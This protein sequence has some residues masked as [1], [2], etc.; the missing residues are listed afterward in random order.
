[1]PDG[2]Y[3]S[4]IC[5]SFSVIA[6]ALE[7]HL[8]K[9]WC[10]KDN[11]IVKSKNAALLCGVFMN[12]SQIKFQLFDYYSAAVNITPTILLFP[13]WRRCSEDGNNCPRS[14]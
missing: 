5:S 1:M 2:S 7:N 3:Q 4:G 8:V 12:Y 9:S 10:Y 6:K 14:H 11:E 13:L